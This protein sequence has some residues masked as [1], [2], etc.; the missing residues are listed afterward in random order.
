[1]HSI[2]KLKAN[3]VCKFEKD[4]TLRHD[5]GSGGKAGINKYNFQLP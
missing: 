1:V 2:L 5:Q 4:T 3:I